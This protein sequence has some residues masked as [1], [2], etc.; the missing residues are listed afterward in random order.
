MPVGRQVPSELAVL[1]SY[2]LGSPAFGDASFKAPN[3]LY[4]AGFAYLF[5]IAL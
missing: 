1:V 2:R 5:G 4:G 3:I